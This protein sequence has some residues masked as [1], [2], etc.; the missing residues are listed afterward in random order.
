M[1]KEKPIIFQMD[2]SILAYQETS[3]SEECM[4]QNIVMRSTQFL[5]KDCYDTIYGVKRVNIYLRGLSGTWKQLVPTVDV[6]I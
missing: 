1:D 5:K 2:A 6:N 3:S 4:N